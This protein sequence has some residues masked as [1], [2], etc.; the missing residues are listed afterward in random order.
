[1][2]RPSSMLQL[3]GPS[4]A[5]PTQHSI[6][7]TQ[8]DYGH[9]SDHTLTRAVSGYRARPL[10]ATP[11]VLPP[12]PIL[13]TSSSSSSTGHSPLTPPRTMSLSS[14]SPSL[15]VMS[16]LT[17][18]S[19]SSTAIAARLSCGY[20][21]GLSL[22]PVPSEPMISG[23]GWIIGEEES[24]H[25]DEFDP[26]ALSESSHLAVPMSDD[27]HRKRRRS[28]NS[29]QGCHAPHASRSRSRSRGR[30]AMEAARSKSRSRSRSCTRTAAHG[31][32][33]GSFVRMRG[34]KEVNPMRRWT[35]A[36]ADSCY[37]EAVLAEFDALHVHSSRGDTHRHRKRRS[38]GLDENLDTA[39]DPVRRTRDLVYGGPFSLQD[40]EVTEDLIQATRRALLSCRD[41]VRTEKSYQTLLLQLQYGKVTDTAI[42]KL[43]H[44]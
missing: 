24:N 34:A 1:M 10:P 40:V 25:S 29:S 11:P 17:L 21:L 27:G 2:V 38:F 13:T 22:E 41:L 4:S 18:E 35:L 14:S 19:D 7:R 43:P 44:G 20:D 32:A 33:V 30:A 26:Y 23:K 39:A 12:T 6:P 15:Q 31:D 37:D 8:S 36:M 9:G 28:P 16:R 42:L 3:I 5:L